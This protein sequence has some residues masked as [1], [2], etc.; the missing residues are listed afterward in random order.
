MWVFRGFI[1]VVLSATRVI[2]CRPA[3][4]HSDCISCYQLY[5]YKTLQFKEFYDRQSLTNEQEHLYIEY[6]LK[7]VL[8]LFLNVSFKE[9]KLVGGN[10]L[11]VQFQTLSRLLVVDVCNVTMFTSTFLA[12]FSVHLSFHHYLFLC[13]LCSL[14]PS[15]YVCTFVYYLFCLFLCVCSF[16]AFFLYSLCFLPVSMFIY[17][18]V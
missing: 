14:K 10:V 4:L 18:L 5:C 3:F 17:M 9:N 12:E 11:Q 16:F 15:L 7:Q 2:D 13:T 1:F 6:C 8:Q